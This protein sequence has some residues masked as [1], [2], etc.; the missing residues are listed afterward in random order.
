MLQRVSRAAVIVD[1]VIVSSIG[2]GFCLL[3]GVEPADGSDEVTA[4]VDKIAGLRV[5][6]DDVGRMNLSIGDVGGELLLVS[7][8]TLLG[9]VRKG[10]RPSFTGAAA[11]EH[12]APLIIA[13]AEAFEQVGIE[14]KTGVFGAH[15]T[16]DLVNDGPVTLV[17][18]VR[19]G[20]V[21]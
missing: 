20:R 21:I 2:P 10:R 3:V 14:T 8:F 4:A 18:E 6:A 13:M 19:D 17:L 11:P 1:D 7:Q 15:M 9:E 5:F 16:V 12:A